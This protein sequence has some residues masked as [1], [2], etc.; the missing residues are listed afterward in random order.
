MKL[1]LGKQ[2]S[3]TDSS[4]TL[5]LTPPHNNSS[6]MKSSQKLNPVAGISPRKRDKQKTV[7]LQ[8][9]GEG[10]AHLTSQGFP[11]GG[12]SISPRSGGLSPRNG[13]LKSMNAPPQ[14][15]LRSDSNSNNNS[16]T[17]NKPKTG[18]EKGREKAQAP[19]AP[20]LLQ[21]VRK[22]FHRQLSRMATNDN[23]HEDADVDVDVPTKSVRNSKN[24]DDSHHSFRHNRPNSRDQASA[25]ARSA[26]NAH[27][28]AIH[29]DEDMPTQSIGN[30]QNIDVGR[31]S[32]RQKRR[33]S[34]H[35]I[36]KMDSASN[37]LMTINSALKVNK[38]N[39][40]RVDRDKQKDIH[41][42]SAARHTPDK[43][44]SPKPNRRRGEDGGGGDEDGGTT[45]TNLRRSFSR[46][47]SKMAS[48]SAEDRSRSPKRSTASDSRSP[49]VPAL[50]LAEEVSMKH[51]HS[52]DSHDSN[53]S[54]QSIAS[55]DSGHDLL[56]FQNHPSSRNSSFGDTIL[57]DTSTHLD[58]DI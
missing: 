21:G 10:Q 43:G 29:E 14:L 17:G 33:S 12:A 6:P 52:E 18:K 7:R 40:K 51:A 22:K 50:R 39:V 3:E 27:V 26:P 49:L 24:I 53:H 46:Q 42:D 57:L 5:S 13:I 30:I 2:G 45:L 1:S 48:M 16:G 58:L 20:E 32:L 8:M 54:M 47:L 23:I 15:H 28:S 55:F 11:D 4:L 19:P 36:S 35:V 37:L 34:R 38:K 25:R 9:P 31:N 41:R 56:R 44:T